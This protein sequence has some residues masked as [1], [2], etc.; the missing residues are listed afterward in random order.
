[1]TGQP[2]PPKPPKTYPRNS[3]GPLWS[4]LINPWFPLIR[5]S[6]K[7]LVLRGVT[8]GASNL[9]FDLIMKLFWKFLEI[10]KIHDFSCIWIE[11]NNQHSLIPPP[12]KWRVWRVITRWSPSLECFVKH[13]CTY[14]GPILWGVGGLVLAAWPLR[15]DVYEPRLLETDGEVREAEGE[16]H[17][18]DVETGSSWGWFMPLFTRCFYVYH[19]SVTSMFK[20]LSLLITICHVPC[21][22]L[23]PIRPREIHT[24]FFLAE[25][26]T[27][28][29]D[30]FVKLISLRFSAIPLRFSAMSLRF[31]AISLRFSSFERIPRKDA[32]SLGPYLIGHVCWWLTCVCFVRR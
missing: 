18:W 24:N 6:I 13:F 5:P 31:S 21:R 29:V 16:N 28:N 27:K 14:G 15:V 8:L 9:R 30:S 23:I 10:V 12:K 19:V 26:I 17:R 3:R 2:T 32:K 20:R 1:M 4:G 22:F 7:P 25:G 11:K